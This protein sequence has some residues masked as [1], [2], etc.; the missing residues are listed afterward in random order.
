MLKKIISGAQTGADIAGLKFAK[1]VGLQTGGYIPKGFKTQDGPKPEYAQLYGIEEHWSTQYPYRTEDNVKSSDA[2]LRFAQNFYSAGEICTLNAIKKW[3][4][5]YF[6][7]DVENSEVFSVSSSQ[8]PK[9]VAKWIIDNNVET[10]NIAG[11][12]E[13]TC[14]GIEVFVMRFLNVVWKELN[15]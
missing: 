6:D 1:S 5:P 2:T 11:N 14:K 8:S 12:S 3:S 10:L 4:K 7:V 9:I 13:K 15:K